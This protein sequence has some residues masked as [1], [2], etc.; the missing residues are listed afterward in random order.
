MVRL[1]QAG[2]RAVLLATGALV[3]AAAAACGGAQPASGSSA[4]SISAP[5]QAPAATQ[6]QSGAA[7]QAQPAAA[8]QSQNGGTCRSADLSAALGSKTELPVDVQGQLGAAG[9]HY[10][11]NLV[12]TNHSGHTCT[13]HGFGGVDVD[14][15]DQGSSGGPTYSLP[16]TGETPVTVT[17]APGASAHT[18]I[19]YIDPTSPE[20][21]PL[22]TPTH[23]EV[24]PPNE[25]THLSVPWTAGTP[26]YQ[27]PQ[28]GPVAASMSPI[29]AGP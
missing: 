13:M 17:L 4:S 9:T 19:D 10:S 11:V 26:V 15:P 25:T 22:W 20:S 7:T 14:G 21:G 18:T 29:T 5:P 2:G 28:D 3:A 6:S 24:T 23:L 12:W 16:R 27:D 1:R 8:N